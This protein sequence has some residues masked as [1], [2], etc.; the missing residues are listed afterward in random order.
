M[1]STGSETHWHPQR[2]E[3]GLR[4]G[5]SETR[6]PNLSPTAVSPEEAA[7]PKAC[8]LQVAWPGP[9]EG[10]HFP[11]GAGGPVGRPGAAVE[12]GLL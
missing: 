4:R 8:R 1:T 5:P 9:P 3:G 2:R 10:R 6:L 12:A 11:V 7:A